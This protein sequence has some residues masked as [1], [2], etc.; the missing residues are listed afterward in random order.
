MISPSRSGL[1]QHRVA[2]AS[3]AARMSAAIAAGS[4]LIPGKIGA[5][6]TSTRIP[7][8]ANRR[9]ARKRCRGGATVGSIRRARRSSSVGRLMQTLNA[10]AREIA[11]HVEIADDQ[12]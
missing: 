11:Q 12:G 1:D 3:A 10:A 8:S 9:T 2:P 7:A 4:S 5:A 6:A